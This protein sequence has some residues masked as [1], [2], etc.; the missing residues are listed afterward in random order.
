MWQPE[1]RL[2]YEYAPYPL[3]G[4]RCVQGFRGLWELAGSKYLPQG[5]N[6]YILYL[7]KCSSSCHCFSINNLEDLTSCIKNPAFSQNETRSLSLILPSASKYFAVVVGLAEYL[8]Y[9]LF[10]F[11]W[12]SR[13]RIRV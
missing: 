6:P 12:F 10:N 3:N 2:K 1:E 11:W 5:P 13:R 8:M 4:L 9:S 7:S